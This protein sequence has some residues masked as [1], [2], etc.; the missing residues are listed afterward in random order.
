MSDRPGLDDSKPDLALEA[1]VRLTSVSQSDPNELTELAARFAS[2]A[3]GGLSPELSAELALEILL[4]E[5]AEQACAATGATGAAIALQRDGEM[6][7]RATSGTTAP[8]LGSR[9]D[10]KS[11]LSGKCV[12]TRQTQRCEDVLSHPDADVAASERLGVRSVIVMPLL[13]GPELIGVFELFS[14]LPYCFGEKDENI[15][16]GF[17]HRVLNN[18]ERSKQPLEKLE[19]TT[20]TPATPAPEIAPVPEPVAEVAADPPPAPVA[21][22]SAILT[23]ALVA[24]IVFTSMLLGMALG[25]HVIARRTLLKAPASRVIDTTTRHSSPEA[26][27]AS[28]TESTPAAAAPS[29]TVQRVPLPPGSLAVYDQGKQVFR[30]TPEDK[31]VQPA[32]AI[33]KESVRGNAALDATVL[34]HVDPAYPDAARQKR[35]QGPVVLDVYIAKNGSVQGVQV[36]SGAAELSDASITAVKQWRFKPVTANGSPAE[37]QTRV[38]LHYVLPK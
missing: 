25:R 15:L 4:N 29:Q 31:G 5:I 26:T 22:G 9:V 17:A 35:I 14:S 11:G 10:L 23:W 36:V 34:Y 30:A 7:C 33:K 19:T 1:G 2:R 12:Q 28:Q 20:Q 13:H 21:Q 32:A 37:M 16:H 6:V 38:T 18:I 24:G 27:P 8:D 3:N